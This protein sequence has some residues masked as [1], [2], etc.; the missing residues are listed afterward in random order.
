MKNLRVKIFFAFV[1][2]GLLGMACFRLAGFAGISTPFSAAISL[3]II[4]GAGLAAAAKFAKPFSRF[5][6]LLDKI[7]SGYLKIPFDIK[8]AGLMADIGDSIDRVIIGFKSLIDISQLLSKETIL[9][10]LLN[11]IISETTK[12]MEAERTTLF[13]YNKEN[14]ELWSYIAQELEI[15][16]IRLPLGKGVA[17]FVA[18]S[19]KILNVPDAYRD[20]RFDRSLDKVTSFTTRSILCAPMFDHKGG[21]LGVIQVLNKT[22][23][24]FNSYDESLL[25]ALAA[26][27]AIAIENARLYE[28]QEYLFKSFIR[29]IAAVVDAR[30]PVTMG[31]SDRVAKY[32]IAIGK[33]LGLDPVDLRI[34]E[35]SAILHDVGKVSIP[36]AVLLKPGSFTPE[37]YEVIKEHAMHTRNI[38]SNIYSNSEL[39]DIPLIASSHHEKLDGSG[40]PYGLKGGEILPLA[41]IIC[42]AD[43]YDALVAY[44]RPYKRAMSVEKALEILKSDALNGKFEAGIVDL[45]VEKKLYELERRS[46]VKISAEFTMEYRKIRL[47]EWKEII[48]IIVQTRD[49]SAGGLLFESD[50]KIEIGNYLEVKLHIRRFTVNAIA[51]VVRKETKDGKN[52]IE[53]TF[54]NLSGD[55]KKR[56]AD[57][58]T[59]LDEPKRLKLN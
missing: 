25:T 34:L 36:D 49:I 3:L 4:G 27:A 33:A 8:N 44:D 16:E 50:D 20:L 56:L 9:D 13:F 30:D 12:L 51:K 54:V 19:G 21:I 17:G 18:Q 29:T 52:L 59:N 10:N 39:K 2:I 55:F 5:Q 23:G 48:P 38:L 1:L 11:L 40:Y 35:Y 47:E 6:V 53:L 31:H 58:L 45:F 57:Y 7:S 43:V 26:Q 15:K 28:S 42:V 14:K 22:D 37:E 41:K 32:S 46:Y 24:P